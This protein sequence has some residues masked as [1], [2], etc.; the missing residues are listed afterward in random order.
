[1]TASDRRKPALPD[2]TVYPIDDGMGEDSLVIFIVETLRPLLAELFASR[3]EQAFV[4]AR[5]FIYWQQHAPTKF[6][7]PHVYVLPGVAPETRVRNW[8]VWETG[9]VPSFALEVISDDRRRTIEDSPRRY[10]EIGVQEVVIFDPEPETRDD[11][12][13]FRVYR[14]LAKRGLTLVQATNADR[15]RSKQLG[16]F[17]RAVGTGDATRVRIGLGPR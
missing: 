11:S 13:R 15:I 14:R 7:A 12:V 10:A 6:V 5:Q 2:P 16:C 3:G 9:I 17:L 1:M 8:K 4:G